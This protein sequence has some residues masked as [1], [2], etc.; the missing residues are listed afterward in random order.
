MACSSLPR[1]SS[2]DFLEHLTSFLNDLCYQKE[3]WQHDAQVRTS[4]GVHP[5]VRV[6]Y[7]PALFDWMTVEN[8]QGPVPNGAIVVKEMYVTLTAPLTEWTV[9]VKDS[10]LSW[11]GWY[12]GDLVN[13]S[14]KDPNAPPEPAHACAEPQVLLNGTGLYC[15][16]CHASAIANS[17]TYS[18]TAFLASGSGSVAVGAVSD[19]V[20][21]MAPFKIEDTSDLEAEQAPEFV[22][23]IPS[24]V[25]ANLK[26]LGA[27]KVPCMV[28]EALDYVVTPSPAHGG[29]QEFVTSDQCS[30]CHD[31]TGTLAGVTP[32]MIFRHPM[33]R[34]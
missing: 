14:P 17:D 19:A 31:A 6:W 20:N 3:N 25:F 1:A 10:N 26:P 7:S 27:V 12:W 11:D 5:F 23:R 16:N 8:R 29:P 15:L 22:D 34:R 28:S 4:D 21:E 13:P 24:S 33:G 30:G 9:M 18:S 2:P 32:N